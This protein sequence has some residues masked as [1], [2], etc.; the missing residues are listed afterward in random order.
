MEYV[1][2]YSISLTLNC[3]PVGTY[4]LRKPV[5]VTTG[6]KFYG[7]SDLDKSLVQYVYLTYHISTLI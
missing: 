4:H 2:F 1:F 6:G 7:A 5:L 3:L